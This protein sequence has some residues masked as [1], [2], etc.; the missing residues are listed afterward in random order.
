MK[1]NLFF[2][3]FC[4]ITIFQP[5]LKAAEVPVTKATFASV[6]TNGV[7]P[8]ADQ[9][10]LVAPC[11][12][13]NT[14]CKEAIDYLT[15]IIQSSQNL[16][17]VQIKE[18]DQ[19][20]REA[21]HGFQQTEEIRTNLRGEVIVPCQAV[22]CLI[23]TGSFDGK[24]KLF[25]IT[26]QQKETS[27]EYPP[28]KAIQIKSAEI[29]EEMIKLNESINRLKAQLSAGISY[30]NLSDAVFPFIQA[31]EEAQN[32]SASSVSDIY[33]ANFQKISEML[34]ILSD[35]WGLY[36]KS[37]SVSGFTTTHNVSCKT[38]KSIRVLWNDAVGSDEISEIKGGLF[39]CLFVDLG[40]FSSPY[41][42]STWQQYMVQSISTKLGEK[43]NFSNQS[44][45]TIPV[46]SIPQNEIIK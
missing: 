28:S 37:T 13:V 33:L 21:L 12:T 25:W 19:K 30:D 10:V 6:E 31:L 36:I 27:E 18:L 1:N 42:N 41:G 38:A 22:N 39:G 8:I 23:Y 26:L 5:S 7:I 4:C 14:N 43:A 3:L 20:I 46:I 9:P 16:T 29:P 35:T 40:E 2:I 11:D 34:N 32:S 45:G 15:Q 24:N 17:P 44:K